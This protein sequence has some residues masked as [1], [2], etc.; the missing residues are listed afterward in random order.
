MAGP[1]NQAQIESARTVSFVCALDFLGAYY[2][3]DPD[4]VPL[5]P[6]RKSRRVHVSYAGRDYRFVFT[7]EKFVNE[8]LPVAA[9]NRGGG[10]AIDLIRH[11]TGLGFVQVVKVCLDA[12]A[13]QIERK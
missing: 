7:G 4:Y 6:G 5:D 11:I 1:W 2:K 13:S 8:L 9:D 10:G 12:R 3:V